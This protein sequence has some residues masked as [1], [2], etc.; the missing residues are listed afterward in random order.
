M[1][2][3]IRE[4]TIQSYK[5]IHA[6]KIAVSWVDKHMHGNAASKAAA[7]DDNS[8]YSHCQE[9]QLQQEIP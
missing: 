3:F 2:L 6:L 9:C 7:A 4:V 1:L 5:C 8:Q